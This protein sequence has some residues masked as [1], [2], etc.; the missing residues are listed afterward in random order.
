MAPWVCQRCKR[1]EV[2]P[3]GDLPPGFDLLMGF[4]AR[5]D[6]VLCAPCRAV[7]L[8]ERRREAAALE[9]RK[10]L[11]EMDEGEERGDRGTVPVT[12]AE[13]ARCGHVTESYGASER[14]TRRCLALLRDECPRRESNWYTDDPAEATCAT[15]AEDDDLEDE[16]DDACSAPV[17]DRPGGDSSAPA[18]TLVHTASPA[19]ERSSAA[20]KSSRV[21]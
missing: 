4:N 18:S 1:S 6:R 17:S 5:S 21:G 3:D 9:R 13:C 14:S 8:A 19:S 2:M 12:Y 16:E 11:V 10:V 20:S 7:V 15:R